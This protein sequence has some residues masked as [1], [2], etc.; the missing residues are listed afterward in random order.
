MFTSF[1]LLPL[2][3]TLRIPLSENNIQHTSF[4][5]QK[6]KFKIANCLLPIASCICQNQ[7]LLKNWF[8]SMR[9]RLPCMKRMLK[10]K[11]EMMARLEK[12]LERK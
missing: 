8:N 9:K 3:L 6:S 7:D 5:I 2:P 4:I 11:D 1:R 12:L 10:E